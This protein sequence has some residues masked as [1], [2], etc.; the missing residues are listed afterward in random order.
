MNDLNPIEAG[1]AEISSEPTSTPEPVVPAAPL[2]TPPPLGDQFYDVKIGGQTRKVPLAELLNGYQRQQ[3]YT[4]KTMALAEERRGFETKFEAERTQLRDFLSKPENVQQLHQYLLQ[5]QGLQDPNSTQPLTSQQ[6]QQ[7]LAA[8]RTRQAQDRTSMIQE[9]E[10]KQME[11][12]YRADVDNHVKA[13]LDQHPELKSIRRIDTILKAAAAEQEP[14]TIEEAKQFMLQA[15]T[16]QV[17]AIRAHFTEQQKVA[18]LN[19]QNLTLKGTEPPG[20]AAPMPQ[21][22]Q[23]GKMGS[24]EFNADVSAYL[25]Q[26]G[27]AA[28][29]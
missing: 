8:E 20:G 5:Q 18:V 29:A 6:L 4:Q 2:A 15:A 27:A 3:D 26:L 24:P 1:Q 28:K 22:K 17:E 10:M 21:P 16:E 14:A 25:Q 13:I 23:V 9:L 19:K 12:S 11:S 7:A